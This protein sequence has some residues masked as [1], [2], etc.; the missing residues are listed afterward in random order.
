MQVERNRESTDRQYQLV[1]R[2]LQLGWHRDQVRVIDEDMGISGSG[3]TQRAG[4]AGMAAEVALGHAGIILALE[5][6][7]FARNN[8]DWYRLLDLCAMT[9]TFIG[10]GDGLYHPAD[11]ND[12]L[13]LGLKGTMSEAELHILRARLNGGIKN[14]AKRG[15]LRRGLPTGFVWGDMDGE[16]RFHP[17]ES[18]LQAIGSIFQFFSET[19]SVRQV[20]LRLCSEQINFPCRRHMHSEIQWVRPTYTEIHAVLTSP[21]YAGAYIY[22]RSR[23]ERYLDEGGQLKSRTRHLPHS[24][25]EVLIPNHHRG[26]I[27]WETYEDNQ[28]RIGNNTRPRPHSAGGAVREGAALLQGIAT[29]GRCG[30]KLKV[31][32]SGKNSIPG[33]HCPGH[34]IANG[35]G[36]YCMRV[37]GQRI[38][39]GVA[40]VFLKTIAPA[41]VAAALQAES[42]MLTEHQEALAQRRHEVERKQYEATRSERRY[43]SVDPENRLVAR[44]LELEWEESLHQL[45]VAKDKLLRYENQTLRALTPAQRQALCELG[46]DLFRVWSAATTTDRDRKQLLRILLEEV[47]IAVDRD[48]HKAQLKLRWSGGPVTELSV[49]LWIVRHAPNRTDEDTVGLLRRLAR[50]YNDGMIAGILNRQGRRTARGLRFNG[51]RVNSL[52]QHWGIPR[53]EPPNDE[54]DGKLLN[55]KQAAELLQIAPSTVHRWINDGIISGEQ[56]TPGAPWRIRMTDKLRSQFVEQEP[57]GYIPMVE[58]TQAL[59]VSRQTV[60]QRVKRGELQAVHVKRGR[61]KGLRIK[62]IEQQSSLFESS[63]SAGVHYE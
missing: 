47:I 20:W 22:G 24:E 16:V 59:G 2:A 6:S 33:Y 9:N 51:N 58:A 48:A 1:T 60:L 62:V 11:F 36:Y 49:D 5:A 63:G 61:R 39:E 32:Y 55:I 30:R 15:E 3:I 21:V 19:G 50:H 41:G 53:F 34:S 25:W 26:F 38:E 46:Q 23:R 44:G 18:V 56:I 10:D 8:A 31:Y 42:Q 45:S 13:V 37:G 52:R 43:K 57:P 27:D 14:K 29:C 12:R 4:F 17:D 35:R 28:K 40:K 7:R 54:P